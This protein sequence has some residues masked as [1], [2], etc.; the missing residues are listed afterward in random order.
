[1]KDDGL[2][3]GTAGLLLTKD[4]EQNRKY[5]NALE[6]QDTVSTVARSG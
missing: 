3:C 5:T 2:M 4:T 6:V 1:M